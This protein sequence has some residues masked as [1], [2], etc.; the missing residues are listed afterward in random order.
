[1]DLKTILTA[2]RHWLPGV[3]LPA[4]VLTD[5]DDA[6]R[7]IFETENTLAELI[8]SDGAYTPCRFVSFTVLD[9]RLDLPAE[10]V[11]CFYDND[12]HTVED[13]LRALDRGMAHIAGMH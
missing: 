3:P 4:Q 1:M 2:L 9:T 10:P 11:F 6:L 5:R 12:S 7:V 8:A 13:I